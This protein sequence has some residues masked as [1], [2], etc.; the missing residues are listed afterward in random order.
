[1]GHPHVENIDDVDI[2]LVET[3]RISRWYFVTSKYFPCRRVVS[4]TGVFNYFL[5]TNLLFYST[6]VLCEE[7][8]F[9][10]IYRDAGH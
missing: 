5:A 7:N 9:G 4:S 1:M 2:A 8:A 3:T 10:R 6:Q